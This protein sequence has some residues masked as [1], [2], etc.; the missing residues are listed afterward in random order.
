MTEVRG[1][2]RGLAWYTAWIPAY[3]GM[4]GP[5]SSSS[6]TRGSISGQ[7]GRMSPSFPTKVKMDSR[8]RGNDRGLGRAAWVCLVH[9]L[10]SRLPGNDGCMGD[11]G[12]SR[13]ASNVPITRSSSR[14]PG[15]IVGPRKWHVRPGS[16]TP[17]ASES[18][19]AR[20]QRP[21]T[22]DPWNGGTSSPRACGSAC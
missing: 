15:S 1:G 6:R 11:R 13:P 5:W 3:A 22:P 19:P 17:S 21:Q 10:D 2:R 16:A 8:V 9:R 7:A 18:H 20:R 4:T 14:T 12:L